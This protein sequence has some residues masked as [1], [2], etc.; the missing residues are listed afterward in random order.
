MDDHLHAV[1]RRVDVLKPPHV[2]QEYLNSQ[3]LQAL[4]RTRRP[5]HRPYIVAIVDERLHNLQTNISISTSDQDTIRRPDGCLRRRRIAALEARLRR[6]G[7]DRL[8][9]LDNR[10]GQL[11]RHGRYPRVQN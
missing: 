4:W 2:S 9:S 7:K 11:A 5:D 8:L 10:R 3:L 6:A 1:S